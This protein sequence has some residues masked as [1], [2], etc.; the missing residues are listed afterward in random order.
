MLHTTTA[1]KRYI[2]NYTDSQF[3]GT[4]TEAGVGTGEGIAGEGVRA[5]VVLVHDIVALCA[6]ISAATRPAL[7]SIHSRSFR[8]LTSSSGWSGEA[9]GAAA[10]KME[11]V[12]TV[13]IEVGV[14]GAVYEGMDGCWEG[15]V[16]LGALYDD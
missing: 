7:L 8:F 9:D 11:V 2:H 16:E 15:V 14:R 3:T 13:E 6:A 5:D 10:G 4:E 12:A 1:Q